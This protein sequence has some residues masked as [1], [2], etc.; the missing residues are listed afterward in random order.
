MEA[1]HARVSSHRALTNMPAKI[2][3]SHLDEGGAGDA[4]LLNESG[5]ML[6]RVGGKAGHS[7]LA[8][9]GR[10]GTANALVKADLRA[11]AG[12]CDEAG[13]IEPAVLHIPR[14]ARLRF[15]GDGPS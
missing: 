10:G 13:V 9:I 4:G 6:D 1:C 2:A 5:M 14:A 3:R 11:P 12:G 15:D 7:S 8:G